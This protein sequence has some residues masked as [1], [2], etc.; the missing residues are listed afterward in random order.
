MDETG[1]KENGKRFWTWVFK[2]DLYV[3]F[4][5]D[6]SRGSQVLLDGLGKEFHGVLGWDY[7]SAYRKSMKDCSITLPFCRAHFIRD[8]RYLIGLP[9]RETQA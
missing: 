5:I 2:A 7:F 8:I 1:H 6:Q 9:D 3:W 4:K